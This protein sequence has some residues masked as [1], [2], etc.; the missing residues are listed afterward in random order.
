MEGGAE[1]A[2]NREKTMA[3]LTIEKAKELAARGGVVVQVAGSDDPTA[4]GILEDVTVDG[5]VGVRGPKFPGMEKG[6]Y[7]Q[8]LPGQLEIDPT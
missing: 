4:F 8:F 6:R 5:W 2:L 7:D 1:A 3:T